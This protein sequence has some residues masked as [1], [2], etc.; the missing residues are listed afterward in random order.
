MFLLICRGARKFHEVILLATASHGFNGA[1]LHDITRPSTRPCGKPTFSARCPSEV[2]TTAKRL[3]DGAPLRVPFPQ[4][5][6]GPPCRSQCRRS[7]SETGREHK[8]TEL[9]FCSER[10]TESGEAL[11]L[12]ATAL[13]SGPEESDFSRAQWVVSQEDD[14][15]A[16]P[17]G[18]RWSLRFV[19]IGGIGMRIELLKPDGWTELARWT[20]A[21]TLSD[22]SEALGLALS[23]LAHERL[24]IAERGTE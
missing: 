5:R 12:V 2:Q 20:R 23:L 7:S 8:L 19:P 4:G 22:A 6:F 17:A 11:R 24:C 9:Q 18:P 10:Y 15:R 14:Y 13:G 21:E 16:T 1:A 3:Q